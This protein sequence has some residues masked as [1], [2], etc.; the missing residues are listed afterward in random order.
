MAEDPKDPKAP[1]NS[2]ESGN[3]VSRPY[4]AI[5]PTLDADGRL[6]NQPASEALRGPLEA[7]PGPAVEEPLELAERTRK[8]VDPTPDSYRPLPPPPRRRGPVVFVVLVG[9]AALLL[10]GLLFAP[11]QWRRQLPVGGLDKLIDRDRPAVL[12]TSE[13]SGASVRIGDQVVGTTPWAGN[14][15]W[16]DAPV[17]V[18]LKGY[19][20]WKGRLIGGRDVTLSATLTR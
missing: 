8:H 4:A 19:R 6:V 14:N 2:T 1:F 18:E 11:K 17:T 15:L 20:P 7:P 5:G 9:I 12:I 13:P 3:D 16:G 10:V